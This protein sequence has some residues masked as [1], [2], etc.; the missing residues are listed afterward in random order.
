[1]KTISGYLKICFI[2]VVAAIIFSILSDVASQ[3]G[4]QNTHDALVCASILSGII[5]ISPFLEAS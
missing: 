2:G 1:M 3:L 4:F 5:A